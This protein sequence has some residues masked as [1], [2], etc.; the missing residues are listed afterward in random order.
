MSIKTCDFSKISDFLIAGDDTVIDVIRHDDFVF[1]ALVRGGE[2]DWHS[3]ETATFFF[4]YKGHLTLYTKEEKIDLAEGQGAFI[5]K[6]TV[7]RS[8]SEERAVI[9]FILIPSQ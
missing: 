4:V 7:H 9:F 5:P 8:V 1:R 6:D 3:H 2:K